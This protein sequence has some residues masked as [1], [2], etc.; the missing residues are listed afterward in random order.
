MKLTNNIKQKKPDTREH[1][2]WFHLWYKNR[3]INPWG[4][5]TEGGAVSDLKGAQQN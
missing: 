1:I 4:L 5:P 3:Q 2:V